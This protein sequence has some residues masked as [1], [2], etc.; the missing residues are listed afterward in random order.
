MH[1]II[2][3]TAQ[4]QA[5]QPVGCQPRPKG[6]LNIFIAAQNAL[7]RCGSSVHN[8]KEHGVEQKAYSLPDNYRLRSVQPGNKFTVEQY[9]NRQ[10]HCHRNIAGN[11]EQT[12]AQRFAETAGT[13]FNAYNNGQRHGKTE[14]HHVKQR[15]ETHCRL[16]R[17]NNNRAELGNKNGYNAENARFHKNC[18]AHGHAKRQV[19]A[20]LRHI[21]LKLVGKNT[22]GRKCRQLMHNPHED[23][24]FQPVGN[25]CCKARTNA[26]QRRSAEFAE[27]KAVV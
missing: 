20:Q 25:A 17:S 12:V 1:I 27:N 2:K 7:Y 23:K 8:L 6:C 11:A 3:I 5:N 22:Q 16:M 18:H 13:G 4:R 10:Q 19:F 14:R 26:A 9:K 21:K 15:S 24:K